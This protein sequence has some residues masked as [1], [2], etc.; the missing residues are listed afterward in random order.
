MEWIYTYNL[1]SSKERPYIPVDYPLEALAAIPSAVLV[2]LLLACQ[3]FIV[4]ALPGLN[5]LLITTNRPIFNM[6][7]RKSYRVHKARII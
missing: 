6:T 2:G 1:S 3:D 7:P 5:F 4:L